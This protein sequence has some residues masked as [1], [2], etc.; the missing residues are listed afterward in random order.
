MLWYVQC[1]PLILV[2]DF[3]RPLSV[4]VA[5][6]FQAGV[7]GGAAEEGRRREQSSD[8]GAEA[9]DEYMGG[10]DLYSL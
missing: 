2:S 7:P 3:S 8:S 5:I 6:S 9:A 10:S 4:E 1:H